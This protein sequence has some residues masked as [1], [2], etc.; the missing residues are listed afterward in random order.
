MSDSPSRKN[1]F[2][3]VRWRR[4]ARDFIAGLL[5]VLIPI[6]RS[7]GADETAPGVEIGVRSSV[8]ERWQGFRR[9]GAIEHGKIYAII[10][11][12]ETPSARKLVTPVK[13]GRLVRQLR[14]ALNARGYTEIAAGQK[15]DVLLTVLYGRG[16]LRNPYLKGAMVDDV[17]DVVPISNILLPDQLL[18][19]R[20]VGYE[21]KL[22][23]A[24]QEKLFIR[25]SAWKNP[26]LPD[27]KPAS[28]WRTT[29]VI[30]SPDIRDLN[31]FT[32]AMLAA[33]ADYFDRPIKE[34]E[35]QVDT[36][37]PTGKV[38]IEPLKVIDDEV[39]DRN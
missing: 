16:F 21:E 3:S 13:E 36:S 5:L 10:S 1:V 9:L 14:E 27:D 2:R 33:G 24:Q 4:T 6:D 29:M 23:G 26:E 20:E 31:Q 15:P 37:A 11:I 32:E 18:R 35:V 7:L 22:Q 12:S 25:V 30:D 17:S 34:E 8:D 28:L 19:Q 39:P 38:I